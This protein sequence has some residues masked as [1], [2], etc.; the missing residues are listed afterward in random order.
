MVVFTLCSVDKS[1]KSN[2][3]EP[4]TPDSLSKPHDSNQ[5]VAKEVCHV[6][7][8]NFAYMKFMIAECT[9]HKVDGC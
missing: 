9:L 5:E 7:R 3:A 2:V 8:I 1:E 6:I 4:T